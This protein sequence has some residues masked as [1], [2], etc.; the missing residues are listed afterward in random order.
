MSQPGNSP[1]GWK[2]QRAIHEGVRAVG[3]P[4]PVASFGDPLRPRTGVDSGSLPLRNA[5]PPRRSMLIEMGCYGIAADVAG[6]QGFPGVRG[7]CPQ[8][9]R[10]SLDARFVRIL[11]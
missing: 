4:P 11:E 5:L 1:G 3:G 10:K 8:R 2:G 7:T 6:G 9:G